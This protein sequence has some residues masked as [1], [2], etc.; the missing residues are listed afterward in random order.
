MR[1]SR[2]YWLGLGS[3]LILS[4]MLTLL[5][6]SQLGQALISQKLSFFPIRQKVTDQTKTE[7]TSEKKLTS[8]SPS[9]TTPLPQSEPTPTSTSTSTSTSTTPPSSSSSTVLS[10]ST[11]TPESNSPVVSNSKDAAAVTQDGLTA[12]FVFKQTC[13]IE[14][15]VDGRPSITGTYSAGASKEVKGAKKIELVSVGNAGG[16]TI[17]LNGKT[18]PSLGKSGRVL[19]NVILTTDTLKSL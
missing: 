18:L 2:S 7:A 12:R 8:E 14:V 15:K 11:S 6:S 19:H 3:G 10:T 4:A 1:V 5:A 9:A 17:T 16:L 13:W